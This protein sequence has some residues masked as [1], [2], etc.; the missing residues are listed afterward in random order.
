[1][2]TETEALEKLSSA[3]P[4]ATLF[5]SYLAGR[6][7][8]DRAVREARRAERE[9]FARRH[10]TGVLT[11]AWVTRKGEFV[12]RVLCGERDDERRGTEDGYR[13]FNPSLGTLLSLEVIQ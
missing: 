4:G 8:T 5:V 11:D 2:L 3:Q 1:M 13:T 12:F 7:P 6:P 10:F 9:G